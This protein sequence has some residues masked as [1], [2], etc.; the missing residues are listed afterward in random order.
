MRSSVCRE[1]RENRENLRTHSLFRH[2]RSLLFNNFQVGLEVPF[3]KM[4]LLR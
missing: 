4:R 2:T 1:N 3:Q